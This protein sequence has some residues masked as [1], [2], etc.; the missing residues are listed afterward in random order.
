[1]ET[2]ND[3]GVGMCGNDLV[4][5]VPKRKMTREEA[6]RHAAW[7]VVLAD[8][9]ENHKAFLEILTAVEET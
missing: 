3:Q 5:L 9:S 1:M 6:L 7:L 4:V 8:H 2:I